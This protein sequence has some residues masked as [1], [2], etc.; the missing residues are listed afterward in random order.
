M[1]GLF[2]MACGKSDLS[3]TYV[4]KDIYFSSQTMSPAKIEDWAQDV[5][6]EFL[7]RRYTIVQYRDTIW[8]GYSE[9]DKEYG[10][11]FKKKSN[12]EYALVTGDNEIYDKV[13][14]KFSGNYNTLTLIDHNS[15]C[16]VEII[17]KKQ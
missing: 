13:S 16:T 3:G 14:A 10:N 1:C 9:E 17:C 2:V 8:I 6:E 4:C 5:R 7:G 11:H 12:L 15:R